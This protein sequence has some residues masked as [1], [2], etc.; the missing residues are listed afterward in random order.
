MS[1]FRVGD[2]VNAKSS[3]FKIENGVVDRVRCM[4]YVNGHPFSRH[5]VTLLKKAEKSQPQYIDHLTECDLSEPSFS[6]DILIVNEF[7]KTM[8]KQEN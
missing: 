1:D 7:I 5:Q 8:I 3:I 2:T 6:Q 4:V